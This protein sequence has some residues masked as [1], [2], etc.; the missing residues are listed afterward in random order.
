MLLEMLLL[1]IYL[2][3]GCREDIAFFKWQPLTIAKPQTSGAAV[4]RRGER[5]IPGQ[6]EDITM[7]VFSC[8][9]CRGRK[10]VYCSGR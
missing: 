9:I 1:V 7:S 6:V 5:K 8:E 4:G 2:G 10:T 3:R